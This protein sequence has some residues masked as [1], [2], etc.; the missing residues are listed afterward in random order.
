MRIEDLR[1][2]YE[3]H[4]WA[5]ERMM[6]SVSSLTPEELTRD[7]QSSH[8][9]VRDTLVHMMSSEWLYLSR[10]HGVF[11]D[12]MLAPESFPT[13]DSIEARW[14]S[15]RRELRTFL[16]AVQDQHLTT[17]MIYHN[18]RGDEVRLPLEVTMQHVVN[19]GTYHRGQVCTLVR[20]LGHDPEPTDL[21]RYFIEERVI[22]ES[23]GIEPGDELEAPVP[24]YNAEEDSL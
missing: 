24:N 4:F 7:L 15:I 3:Y 13:L 2:L 1:T 16:G 10:W 23:E 5:H 17:L 20:Q 11:P 12:T 19:H 22:E 6:G 18:I 21:F 8:R 9:S 14:A